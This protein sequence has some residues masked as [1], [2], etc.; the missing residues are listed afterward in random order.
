MHLAIICVI[1][2]SRPRPLDRAHARVSKNRAVSKAAAGAARRP[3]G[4]GGAHT[5]QPKTNTLL[6]QKRVPTRY[7]VANTRN[8]TKT[9]I[10]LEREDRSIRRPLTF[11]Q[12]IRSRLA[13]TISFPFDNF[14][15]EKTIQIRSIQNDG[16]L[17][18]SFAEG[19]IL[20]I[21]KNRVVRIGERRKINR[22]TGG[23][24]KRDAASYLLSFFSYR[25]VL[26]SFIFIL[27]ARTTL[28][29]EKRG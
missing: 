3:K 25:M 6:E 12:R 19:K 14:F 20:E 4:A 28:V 23:A 24:P 18:R 16:K 17:S 27:V 8:Q 1:F 5:H 11:G 13:S 7:D 22:H 29:H 15:F 10:H 21:T 26:L 9:T 2:T